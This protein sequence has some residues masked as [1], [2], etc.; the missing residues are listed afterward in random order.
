MCACAHGHFN[1]CLRVSDVFPLDIWFHLAER[2]CNFTIRKVHNQRV[3]IFFFIYSFI[4]SVILP[5]NWKI[6]PQVL[7][8]V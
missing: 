4:K 6:E 8:F 5:G 2:K 1:I 3:P 7:G